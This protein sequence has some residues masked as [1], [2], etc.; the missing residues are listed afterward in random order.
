[1]ILNRPRSVFFHT[2]LCDRQRPH[3]ARQVLEASE[4]TP[5]Q[6]LS[7]MRAGPVRPTEMG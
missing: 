6:D 1:M 3:E 2:H 5:D 7:I 4:M